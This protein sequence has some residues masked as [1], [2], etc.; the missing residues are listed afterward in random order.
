MS[1]N[2]ALFVVH[3]QVLRNVV[4]LEIGCNLITLVIFAL[5]LNDTF[6]TISCL[7]SS[8]EEHTLLLLEINVL[9]GNH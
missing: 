4:S 2:L 6:G 1:T 3:L 8:V 5:Y 9:G 7:K